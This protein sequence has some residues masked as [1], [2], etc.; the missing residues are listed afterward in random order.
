MKRQRQGGFLIAKIHQLAGRIFSRK[1]KEAGIELNPAQGRIMFVLWQ[2]DRIPI[3][4]LARR[5][6]LGNSTLTS[7][8]DRLESAGYISRVKNPEDRRVMLIERT[9]KDKIFERKYTGVS[10]DMIRLFYRD[11]AKQEIEQF[12]RQLKMILDNLTDYE[13]NTRNERFPERSVSHGK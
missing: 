5:T 6:S 7:M 2:K 3:N 8:L 1:L 10:Q 4:E 9:A 13:T 11:F 12:E